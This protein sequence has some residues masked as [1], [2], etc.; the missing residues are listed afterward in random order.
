VGGGDLEKSLNFTG[1]EEGGKNKRIQR[2]LREEKNPERSPSQSL[3][4]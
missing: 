2:G 1:T 4:A 3:G